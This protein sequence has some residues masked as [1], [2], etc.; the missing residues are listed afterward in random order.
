MNRVKEVGVTFMTGPNKIRPQ[1]KGS[2]NELATYLG[3]PISPLSN[4]TLLKINLA[5]SH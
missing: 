5:V 1:L 2:K 3:S 4:E